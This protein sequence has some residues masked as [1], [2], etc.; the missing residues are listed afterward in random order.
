M[1]ELESSG[2]SVKKARL[3]DLETQGMVRALESEFQW[4]YLLILMC[5]GV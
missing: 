1:L 2:L 4:A 5:T 3:I